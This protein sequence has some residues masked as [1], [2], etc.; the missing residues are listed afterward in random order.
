M[1]TSIYIISIV[2]IIIGSLLHLLQWRSLNLKTLIKAFRERH[3]PIP[4]TYDN[5]A[6]ALDRMAS[7]TTW[8]TGLQT[9]AIATVGLLFK[10]RE[11]SIFDKYY[12][13]E[14]DS[15]KADTTNV[16]IRLLHDLDVPFTALLNVNGTSLPSSGIMKMIQQQE[17][18]GN[19]LNMYYNQIW[20]KDSLY[21]DPSLHHDSK[22]TFPLGLYM[23]DG[24]ADSLKVRAR[25]ITTINIDLMK[26][27]RQYLK[28]NS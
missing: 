21:L 18:N 22:Q 4:V 27:L 16:S 5:A 15:Q 7:W 26:I 1:Q 28:K 11:L 2:V 8:L 12:G 23:S 20:L 3:T 24:A 14:H 13:L 6:Q 10:D 19:P 25:Q 9:A 17:A